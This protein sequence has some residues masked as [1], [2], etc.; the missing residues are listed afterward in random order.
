ML[1]LHGKLFNPETGRFVRADA[2]APMIERTFAEVDEDWV[3]ARSR[4]VLLLPES[5]S[6]WAP[7][8]LTSGGF[9]YREVPVSSAEIELWRRIDGR[10]TLREL[11]GIPPEWTS[12]D[13]Q[14]VQ[15]RPQRWRAG[16]PSLWR[17]CAEPRPPGARSPEMWT[18]GATSLGDFHERIDD[19]ETRFDRAETTLAH[20]F[21][22]P[23]P[24]LSGRTWGQA[25]SDWL[26]PRERLLEI[27]GGLGSV[28]RDLRA[29]EHTR[30]D[31]SAALL[32]AQAAMA[33]QSRGV[34]GDATALPFPQSHFDAVV[35]NEVLA[36]LP[37]QRRDGRLVNVGAFACVREVA[38]VLR[39][40][41]VAWLSEFG[42]LD[43]DPEETE[44]LD[45]PEVSID[46]AACL[47]VAE[48]CGVEADVERVIDALGLEMSARWLHRGSWTAL[49]ARW[50][51][52]PARAWTSATVPLPEAVEGLVDVSLRDEGPGPLPGRF[53]VLVL[54]RPTPGAARRPR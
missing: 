21:S 3:P 6:L 28:S 16:D 49:R 19:A 22:D 5:G 36:D 37:A 39:P 17:R 40:G 23:H 38:R 32:E 24:A 26:G 47:A 10:R 51:D 48:D 2:P 52:L 34:L 53:F 35:V 46:F 15:L 29:R 54:R 45:H 20:V 4:L 31:R 27:G 7:A 9:T 33:P 43:I 11:G 42:G 50:P 18:E 12:Y 1:R 30:L 41:G 44:Q 13:L 14:A 25:L 8:T